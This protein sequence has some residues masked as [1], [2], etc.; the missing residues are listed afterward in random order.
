MTKYEELNAELT[1]T[2]RRQADYEQS[3]RHFA[4]RLLD[5]FQQYLGGPAG[6]IITL[7]WNPEALRT[8]GEEH[9]PRPVHALINLIDDDRFFRF[10]IK[11][12]LSDSKYVL[13]PVQFVRE[14]GTA[15]KVS[16]D[17]GEA[18][19]VVDTEAN[20]EIWT[21]IDTWMKNYN[22]SLR[23]GLDE[24]LRGGKKR[25]TIGFDPQR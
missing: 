1:A 8:G 19:Y 10:M 12:Q 20:G 22:T 2:F 7:P 16:F 6:S 18:F 15:W 21:L 9:R 4:A 25:Q 5:T 3:G 17:D 23:T 11:I 24:F 14:D 13:F